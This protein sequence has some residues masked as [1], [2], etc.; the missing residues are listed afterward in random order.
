MIKDKN[1]KNNAIGEHSRIG[2]YKLLEAIG[3]RGKSMVYLAQ[4]ETPPNQK[5]VLR[6]IET[7]MDRQEIMNAFKTIKQATALMNTSHIARFYDSGIS[8]VGYAYFVTEYVP[9]PSITEY[10][11]KYRLTI[12]ERLALFREICQVIRHA[13]FKGIVHAGLRPSSIRVVLQDGKPVIKIVDFGIAKILADQDLIDNALDTGD[14]ADAPVYMSP[15]QAALSDRDV[16]TRTDIYSLGVLLYELLVGVTPFD[17]KELEKKGFME[18]LRK[19][20]EDSPAR[21]GD[22]VAAFADEHGGEIA[23][24]RRTTYAGMKKELPADLDWV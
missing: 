21:P 16:D 20:R 4:Q 13:H 17:K 1:N 15:E 24:K 8:A 7:A 11:D 23:R 14:E 9:G 10:C 18:I 5:V 2:D 22:R 3:K 12:P 19:I 6:L